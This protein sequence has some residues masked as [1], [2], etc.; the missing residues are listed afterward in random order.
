[1]KTLMSVFSYGVRPTMH[2]REQ[3][4]VQLTNYISFFLTIAVLV[5]IV[6]RKYFFNVNVTSDQQ[7]LFLFFLLP[8]VANRFDFTTVARMLL[9][10]TPVFLIWYAFRKGMLIAEPI[11]QSMYDGIRL[12]LISV[13]LIPYLVFDRSR[14]FSLAVC[15]LPA[16]CSIVF[17]DQITHAI[18]IGY[19]NTGVVGADFDL[20]TMRGISAYFIIN[21]ACYILLTMVARNDEVNQRLIVELRQKTEQIHDQNR[22]LSRSR[23]DLIKLNQQLERMVDEKSRDIRKQNEI[24]ANYAFTNAHKLR[25]PVARILGLINV[26]R[27]ETGLDFSWFFAKLEAETRDIDK[28]IRSVS[29]DLDKVDHSK[30]HNK[31]RDRREITRKEVH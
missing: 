17:F 22:E 9:S 24:L 23:Q 14:P 4:Q 10:W 6:L 15:I 20:M 3:R 2:Y 5:Q 19:G 26:S 30:D 12:F 13:S 18:G 21:I 25:G 28:V 1:M 29:E 16:L 31:D 27:L 8:I 11:E 7:F